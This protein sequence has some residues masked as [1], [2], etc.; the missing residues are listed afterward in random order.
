MGAP[1]RHVEAD[2]ISV[3]TQVRGEMSLVRHDNYGLGL[4]LH[5]VKCWVQRSLP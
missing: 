1:Q 3:E 2:P 4:N 5:S